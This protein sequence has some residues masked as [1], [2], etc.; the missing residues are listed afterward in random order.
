[1]IAAAIK[2]VKAN[3]SLRFFDLIRGVNLAPI[4]P[5]IK[6]AN[7][8]GKAKLKSKW[9]VLKCPRNPADAVNNTSVVEV[10]IAMC[11]GTRIAKIIRGTKKDPPDI[12][13]IPE[14]NPVIKTTGTTNMRSI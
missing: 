6:P 11:V 7:A 13:T 8:R 9:P 12:P 10:P 3:I 14:I 5:P 1:M 2:D 4:N